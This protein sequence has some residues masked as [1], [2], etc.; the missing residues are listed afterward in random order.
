MTFRCFLQHWWW[1]CQF[2]CNSSVKRSARRRKEWKLLCSLVEQQQILLYLWS[3][4]SSVNTLWPGGCCLSVSF[5]KVCGWLEWH[6]VTRPITLLS[7]C[8]VTVRTDSWWQNPGPSS[9]VWFLRSYLDYVFLSVFSYQ[10]KP[11]SQHH[12]GSL[13][14]L[15]LGHISGGSAAITQ[16]EPKMIHSD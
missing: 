8:H 9:S 12:A 2:L 10:K 5:D 14:C 11:P 13:A 6:S 7:L 1:V 4:G 3:D 16:R 15:V